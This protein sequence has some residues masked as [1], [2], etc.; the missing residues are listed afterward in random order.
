MHLPNST[1]IRL[2][3]HESQ[4]W[5]EEAKPREFGFLPIRMFQRGEEWPEGD[6]W[7]NEDVHEVAHAR[8]LDPGGLLD[9]QDGFP[10]APEQSAHTVRE[11]G[12]TTQR[13]GRARDIACEARGDD[14]R[15]LDPR[16]V[17]E[18]MVGTN[19]MGN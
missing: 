4:K 11:R 7:L 13:D 5:L 1:G 14:R 8:A 3:N 2:G 10:D 15:H 12:G 19:R 6:A 16:A 9:R 17:K 18:G